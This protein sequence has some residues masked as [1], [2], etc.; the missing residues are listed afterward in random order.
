MARVSARS[1]ALARST[2]RARNCQVNSE[3]PITWRVI[4]EATATAIITA[5]VIA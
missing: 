2:P 1:W 5:M 3:P 4:S